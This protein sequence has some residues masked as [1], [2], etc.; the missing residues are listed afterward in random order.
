VVHVSTDLQ[1]TALEAP[2]FPAA[3]V[4]LVPRATTYGRW[5]KRPFDVAVASL[6]LLVL[7][8]VMLLIAFLIPVLLG[9][10]GILYRQER[11]GRDGRTFVIY[12]F[13]SMLRDRRVWHDPN[14]IGRERRVNHKSP[15]DPRHRPFGR[16]IRATSL[17]ELP[18]LVNIVRGEMSLVGP[19]PELVAVARREGFANH[20]RH[21]AR[22]GLTGS[23][24]VSPLRSANRISAGLHL[25]IDY[26]VHVRF[27][28]DLEILVRTLTIPFAR[29][30][31]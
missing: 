6:A 13:R 7:A 16:F 30:G 20:P 29:R 2:D 19:R 25:D 17:D 1:F 14:Y 21:I 26:V 9:P 3:T 31:S 22:P 10:G 8:P 4:L 24:Q 5:L 23:F 28:R 15:N 27:A 12:K 18:Q 11:V